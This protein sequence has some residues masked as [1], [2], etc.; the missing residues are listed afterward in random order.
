MSVSPMRRVGLCLLLP[1]LLTAT[2]CRTR[3]TPVQTFPSPADVAAVTEPKPYPGPNIVI[4]PQAKER[5][6]NAVEGWG[7]RVQNAGV[8]IC[9]W[10]RDMGMPGVPECSRPPG[11]AVR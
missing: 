11:P 7:D 10:A 8:R 1:A 4:D 3:A 2:G 5:Y 9:L 6:D